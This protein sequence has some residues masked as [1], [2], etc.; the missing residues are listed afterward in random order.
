MLMEYAK[1]NRG[2][3]FRNLYTV[4]NIKDSL[5]DFLINFKF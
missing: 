3:V 5:Q 2:C 1:V 4:K